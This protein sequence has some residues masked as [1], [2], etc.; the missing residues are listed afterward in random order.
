M[1]EGLLLSTVEGAR[2]SRETGKPVWR[3][4]LERFGRFLLHTE[5]LK[6]VNG[7]LTRLRETIRRNQEKHSL[8]LRENVTRTVVE[9]KGDPRNPSSKGEI[10]LVGAIDNS[11]TASDNI[12]ASLYD[13]EAELLK[14]REKLY[15]TSVL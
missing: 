12:L 8:L 11:V 4:H 3:L 15:A 6:T 7:E 2:Q 10:R 14:K 13:W 9:W 5:E 1:F